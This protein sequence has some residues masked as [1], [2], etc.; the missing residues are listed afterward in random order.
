M[1]SKRSPLFSISRKA[2][3][4]LASRNSTL[5]TIVELALRSGQSDRLAG[6]IEARDVIANRARGSSAKPPLKVKQ[7]RARPRAIARAAKWFS[8]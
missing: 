8:R 3:K 5:P 1:V 7:S 4:T 6:N 2:S